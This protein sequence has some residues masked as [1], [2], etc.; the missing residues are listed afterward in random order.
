MLL[1]FSFSLKAQQ[2]IDLSK[3][4][5]YKIYATGVNDQKSSDYLTHTLEKNQ[6]A[7][8]SS[9]DYKNGYGYVIVE[10]AYMIN[11]IEKYI[12]NMMFGI[13]LE[14]Y[15]MV[16]LTPDLFM[17]AYYLRGNITLENKSKE[18]PQFIQ[19]GPYTQFSNDVYSYV[20]KNWIEK[21]PDAYKAMF[22]P[23]PLTPEQ[24]QEQNQKLN[25]KN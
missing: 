22:K 20:K 18:L 7:I 10:A 1:L 13:R 3:W 6:L 21:Y 23:E 15:D 5:A 2:N 11:E 19:F 14:N 16:E 4:F 8:M 24:I 25:R 17:D 12:H 9:F